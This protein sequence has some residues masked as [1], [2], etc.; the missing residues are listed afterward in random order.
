VSRSAAPGP[1]RP[2]LARIMII[3]SESEGHWHGHRASDCIMITGR[4]AAIGPARPGAV[5]L[6]G[7][8]RPG[9]QALARQAPPSHGGRGRPASGPPGRQGPPAAA[10]RPPGPGQPGGGGESRSSSL[11]VA[12]DHTQATLSRLVLTESARLRVRAR[13]RLAMPV[14]P[15]TRTVESESP[16]L[17]SRR[18]PGPPQDPGGRAGPGRVT[19]AAVGD[20]VM[21]WHPEPESAWQ[22][23]SPTVTA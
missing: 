21:A 5:P 13:L 18:A 19:A 16:G 3:D 14:M 9:P 1:A 17:D 6:P 4:A 11:P 2:P 8:H 20:S 12:G 7:W 22:A 10:Q 15:V 23:P